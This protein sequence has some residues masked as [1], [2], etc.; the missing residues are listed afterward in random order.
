MDVNEKTI[1]RLQFDMELSGL[2]PVSQENYTY[3]VKKF[4]EYIN[5]SIEYSTTED[6]R[7][8]LHYLRI[9]KGLGIGT[10]NY[11]HTCLRFLFGVTLERPWHER[12]I[13]R[14]RGYKTLPVVLSRQ[15]VKRLLD[16]VES[17]KYKAIFSTVYAGGLRISEVCR[18]RIKDIDS[19][20]MQIFIKSAKGNKDRYTI[21]SKTN[22]EIL[23][24]YWKTCGKPKEWLF[25]GTKDGKPLTTATVREVMKN[26][27]EKAGI[28]KAL[29]V[30]SLRH[31]FAT[32]LLEQG[33]NIFRIKVLLGHSSLNSTCRYLH[34]VN[35]DYFNVK[36]P[37]D[38]MADMEIIGK[39]DE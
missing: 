27:R 28:N 16:S 13:P 1:E 24:E 17:M 2:S 6:V 18:L 29:T 23:R 26:S 35:Q 10:V 12:K 38:V 32:H 21:L 19:K 15:E 9:D 31:A 34:M 22:L 5:K 25:P 20:N 30:H 36:S 14:L 11:F 39:K 8:F 4:G 7:Q 3:H 33:E 37:L